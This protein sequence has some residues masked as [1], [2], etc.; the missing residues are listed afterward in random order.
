MIGTTRAANLGINWYNLWRVD[1]I[2]I[3]DPHASLF[4]LISLSFILE[5]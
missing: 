1:N 3:V 2:P 4:A 5:S